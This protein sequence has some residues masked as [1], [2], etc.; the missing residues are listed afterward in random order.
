[1]KH[2]EIERLIQK[3]IDREISQNEQDRLDKHLTQCPDCG[4][5]YK[6]MMQ[7][8]KGLSELIQFYPKSDFNA[9][10]IARLGIKRRFA[11][12]KAGIAFAGSWIAALLFFAYSPLPKQVFSNIATSIPMIMRL[13]DK[14][15][16]VVTSLTEVFSPAFKTSVSS[17]D[18]IVGLVFSIAFIFFLGKALQKEVKCKA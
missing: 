5:F 17:L 16:L 2:K 12:T 18:P 15:E 10:V 6:Q 3:R 8:T 11:W 9:R 4:E 7:T 1:M 14:V 13:F